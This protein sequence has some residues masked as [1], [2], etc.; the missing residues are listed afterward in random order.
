MAITFFVVALLSIGACARQ[1]ESAYKRIY[2]PVNISIDQESCSP[3][4]ALNKTCPLYI[5]L[6]MSFG[7]SYTSSGVIP[8]MEVALDQ[9]NSDPDMLPGYTLHYTLKDSRVQDMIS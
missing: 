3:D 5:A 6:I 7:G 8:A 2:P 1:K 4:P 9:I